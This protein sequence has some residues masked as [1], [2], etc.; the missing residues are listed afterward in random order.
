[1]RR[2]ENR[3]RFKAPDTW[4]QEYIDEY[5]EIWEAVD[6][7]ADYLR[8]LAW[9]IKAKREYRREEL[10]AKGKAQPTYANEMAALDRP[11]AIRRK[12]M[13]EKTLAIIDYC[14]KRGKTPMQCLLRELKSIARD[15]WLDDLRFTFPEIHNYGDVA[16]RE[17]SA[18]MDAF[19][20]FKKVYYRRRNAL[21]SQGL[22]KTQK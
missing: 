2:L 19:D 8:Q 21:K 18:H 10:E 14:I 16:D 17:N 13:G 5:N 7:A 11:S 9:M 1:L 4:E 22:L 6:R 15:R 12:K 3:H 20:R